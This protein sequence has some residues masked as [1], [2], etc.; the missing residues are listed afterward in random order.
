MDDWFKADVAGV[1]GQHRTDAQPQILNAGIAFADMK[2]LIA[3][4]AKTVD[5]QRFQK[6]NDGVEFIGVESS[7]QVLGVLLFGGEISEHGGLH[8]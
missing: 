4:S 7:K 8:Y 6:V 1:R 5:L 3:E 2:E